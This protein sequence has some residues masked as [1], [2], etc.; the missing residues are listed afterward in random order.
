MRISLAYKKWKHNQSANT[1]RKY[2]RIHVQSEKYSVYINLRL[3][4]IK[5]KA[6]NQKRRISIEH[7]PNQQEIDQED[8]EDIQ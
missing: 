8:I 3:A 6:A 7:K 4:E 1:V 5:V 2:Q